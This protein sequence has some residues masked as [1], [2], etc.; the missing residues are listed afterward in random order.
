MKKGNG[1]LGLLTV[2]LVILVL[3]TRIRT[4][5]VPDPLTY[6]TILSLKGEWKNPT[7]SDDKVT[8]SC[9]L[10]EEPK[11]L[12][13]MLQTH[14]G[15]YQIWA[16]DVLIYE[17]Q[18][19]KI[20]QVHLYHLPSGSLLTVSFLNVSNQTEADAIRQSD[21]TVGDR[22]GIYLE[23]IRE[24]LYA[25]IFALL[26]FC[27][28]LICIVI[29]VLMRK[30]WPSNMCESI[31]G[32]GIFLLIAGIWVLT[33]SKLLLLFTQRTGLVEVVSFLSFFCIPLSLTGFTG[34]LIVGREKMFTQLHRIFGI[35][36]LVYLFNYLLNAVSGAVVLIAEHV[37]MMITIVLIVRSCI[38]E[39]RVCRN[40]KVLLVM[41]GYLFFCICNITAF[42][43]FYM[44]NRRGYSLA[45]VAGISC[46]AFF[47]ACSAGIAVYEQIRKNANMAVYA[48]LAFFDRMTGAANRTAF[49][50]VKQRDAEFAGMLGYIMVDANNLKQINDSCGH[51]AGDELLL[52]ISES[53]RRAADGFGECYR[54]GGD[55]FVV[56]V[57]DRAEQDMVSCVERIRRELENAEQ[58]NEVAVSAA[59]GFSWSDAE[60][61]DPDALLNL[62]DAAMY[63]DKRRMKARLLQKEK[64]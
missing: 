25:G 38:R 31:V 41:L 7:E 9:H 60:H 20:G 19:G 5:M 4:E 43:L 35:M 16:D 17:A 49:L 8:Y 33:D 30:A 47:F 58:T 27:V 21:I 1:L 10:P 34:K 57:Q 2:L 32:L 53:I 23:L 52:R 12:L 64:K 24:N 18:E 42:V 14:W 22:S 29:G 62:A 44:R 11:D 3:W 63:E 28:F 50:E 40:N 54:I 61:K 46:F 56:R 36:M 45:Y 51:Q 6:G 15:E 48:K 59:V 55:E 39:L 37:L 26:S 13:C